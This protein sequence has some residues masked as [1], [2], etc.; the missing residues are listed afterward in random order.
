[1]SAH[2]TCFYCGNTRMAA[3]KLI[4]SKEVANILAKQQAADIDDIIWRFT[5]NL[6]RTVC[7][8]YDNQQQETWICCCM[9]CHHW[10]ARR[11]DLP[12][13]PLPMQNLLW[14]L[15]CMEWYD[16]QKCDKRIL[17]RLSKLIASEQENIYQSC[18][19]PTEREGLRHILHVC[20]GKTTSLKTEMARF[21][22]RQN[23]NSIFLPHAQLA[24]LLRPDYA[25]DSS[26]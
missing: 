2:A 10:M 9:N 11:S 12:V 5:S 15:T 18:F 25:L 1:M 23:G 16:K 21:Y 17:M 8:E 6:L 4:H 19:L 13:P 24:N 14:F 7:A 26:A 3:H 22:Q 20:A